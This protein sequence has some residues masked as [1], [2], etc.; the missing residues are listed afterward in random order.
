MKKI[1]FLTTTLMISGI[2]SAQT[3]A[4][5]TRYSDSEI[6]ALIQNYKRS[7]ERDVFAEGM[8]LEKFQRDFPK[9]HGIDWETN[10]EIYEVE[11]DLKV[12]DFAA[13]YD[14][15]GHLLMYRQD[16]RERELPAIVKTAAE[17]KYP[18]YRFEDIEKIIRGTETLYKLEMEYKDTE[19]TVFVTGGG[20]IVTEKIDY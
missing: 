1:L 11:F 13:F 18:K 17:A 9:A 8:L 5:S 15:D 2:L 14:K 16:I 19:V 7:R 6:I 3:P 12:R 4:I 10:G 20:K